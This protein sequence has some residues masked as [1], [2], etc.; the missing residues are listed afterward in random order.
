MPV[1]RAVGLPRGSVVELDHG[2]D[3]LVDVYVNGR[4][5][6]RAS[7]VVADGS[8]WAVRIEELLPATAAT[9]NRED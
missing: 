4:R 8:E 2:A 7:L 1:A 9:T 6:A 5:F 3:D